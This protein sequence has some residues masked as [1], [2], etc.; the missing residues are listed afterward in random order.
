MAK[1]D[2]AELSD[3]V[4]ACALVEA[5][6]VLETE[7]VSIYALTLEE[8]IWPNRSFRLGKPYMVTETTYRDPSGKELPLTLASLDR[9]YP[10]GIWGASLQRTVRQPSSVLECLQ[11]SSRSTQVRGLRL[12]DRC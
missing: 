2:W 1:R 8:Q 3:R 6:L 12:P 5:V 11:G 10:N 9:L 7:E 4:V